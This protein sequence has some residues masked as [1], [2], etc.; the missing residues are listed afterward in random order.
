MII[1]WVIF[2]PLCGL[3]IVWLN[4]KK[5]NK[6]EVMVKYRILYQGYRPDSF[7]WEFVNIFRKVGL[8]MINVF[9]A[10]FDPVYR[11]FVAALLLS[12]LLRFQERKRPYKVKVLNKL[13][14]REFLSSIATLYGG[15]YFIQPNTPD[16]LKWVLVG[17]IF[18]A[19]IWFFVLWIHLFFRDSRFDTLKYLSYFF[20]KLSFLGKKYWEYDINNSL[21]TDQGEANLFNT[22]MGFI[23]LFTGQK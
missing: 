7:Y 16:V 18:I 19:N 11:T 13:E 15:M 20:G 22:N 3:F 2:M 21:K 9:M 5:L 4:R 12:V 14:Q 23:S 10:P 6:P 8:V 1:I 17:I